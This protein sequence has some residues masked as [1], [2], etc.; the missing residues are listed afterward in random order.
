MQRLSLPSKKGSLAQLVQSI[1]LTSRGSAVRT[2]QLPQPPVRVSRNWN[3]FSFTHLH[4]I[5]IQTH[6]YCSADG[7]F[8]STCRNNKQFIIFSIF[9]LNTSIRFPYST[10]S[11]T[12]CH[13]NTTVYLNA[14]YFIY[15]WSS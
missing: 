7:E 3:L 6:S 10:C 12:L 4:T 9:V 1:C 8:N 5:C 13:C 15:G 14:D 11:Y 2:R